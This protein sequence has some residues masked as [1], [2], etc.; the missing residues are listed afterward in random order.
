MVEATTTLWR[1]S[2]KEEE[3]NRVQWRGRI[4]IPKTSFHLTPGHGETRG[5][6]ET[7]RER[8]RT[9]G[10]GKNRA[11]AWKWSAARRS[12]RDGPGES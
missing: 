6:G 9:A 5:I 3:R 12:G 11:G 4:E 8:L 2:K 1:H 10:P 7:G